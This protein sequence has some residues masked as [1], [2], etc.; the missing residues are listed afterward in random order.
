MKLTSGTG[1][2]LLP[3][4]PVAVPLTLSGNEQTPATR[5]AGTQGDG[6]TGV[7]AGS[8]IGVWEATTNLVTNGGFETNTTGWATIGTGTAIA[9]STAVAKFGAA[10]LLVT[11]GNSDTFDGAVFSGL[12]LTDATVYTFSAWVRTVTGSL[13][14]R[15]IAVDKTSTTLGTGTLTATTEWQRMSVTFTANANTPFQLR[16]IQQTGAASAAQYYVDGVQVEAQPLATPY[17]HTDGGTASRSAST[18]MRIYNPRRYFNETQ[19]WFA[20]GVRWGFAYTQTPH[21]STL[22]YMGSWGTAG[23]TRLFFYWSG[24]N[25]ICR[26]VNGANN[27]QV[28]QADADHARGDIGLL[29]F[30]WEQTT[31]KSSVNGAAFATGSVSADTIPDLSGQSYFSIGRDDQG[32]SELDSAVVFAALGRGTLTDANAAAINRIARNNRIDSR[33]EDLPGGCT[34]KWPSENWREGMAL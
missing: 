7:Y 29:L 27:G 34:F 5:A 20:L 28:Q 12:T 15:I 2:A 24:S 8:S 19:G 26:R 18:G 6:L 23:T 17:V 13:A 16:V 1:R 25:I 30:A 32:T 9:R 22:V 31:L 3:S 10:S 33:V 21:A 14:M 11:L 4:R